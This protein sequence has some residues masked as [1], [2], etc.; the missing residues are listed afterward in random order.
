M[1]LLRRVEDDS[2]VLM[3]VHAEGPIVADLGGLPNGESTM[4]LDRPC[5]DACSDA[6]L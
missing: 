3:G 4:P 5:H 6:K 2:A 1:R